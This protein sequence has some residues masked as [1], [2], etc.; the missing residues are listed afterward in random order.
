MLKI[1]QEVYI[2]RE[3]S[4]KL[5]DKFGGNHYAT[6]WLFIHYLAQ[7]MSPANV[8]DKLRD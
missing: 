4:E 2:H 1:G 6:Y 7:T 5:R 8:Y 3:P